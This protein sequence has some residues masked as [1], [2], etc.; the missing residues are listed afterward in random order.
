MIGSG[1]KATPEREKNMSIK[2][3]V[4]QAT[5]WS[6]RVNPLKKVA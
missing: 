4:D 1:I 2:R 6:Q 3:S 5:G